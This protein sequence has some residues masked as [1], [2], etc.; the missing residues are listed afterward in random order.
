MLSKAIGMQAWFVVWL[1]EV[2][3][4]PLMDKIAEM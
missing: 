1:S 3:S 2:L 4:V